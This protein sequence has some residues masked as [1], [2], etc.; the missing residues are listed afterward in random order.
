MVR[1]TFASPI[2][3]YVADCGDTTHVD[4]PHAKN[5]DIVGAGIFRS[6][7]AMLNMKLGTAT[8]IWSLGSYY[9]T[10]SKHVSRDSRRYS[11]LILLPRS[12]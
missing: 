9:G 10:Y 7:E 3:S 4:S 12:C 5:S 2:S 6:S 11:L 1:V 8:E